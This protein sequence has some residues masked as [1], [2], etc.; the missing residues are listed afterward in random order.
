LSRLDLIVGPNGAGKTTFVALTLG[1]LLPGSV[2][3]NA[4][5]IARQR[6]PEAAAEHAYAAAEIAAATREQLIAARQAFIAET[7]FSHPSKLELLDA[8]NSAGYTTVLHVLIVPEELAVARVAA[9]VSSGGHS[10]P[11]E[12]IRQRFHRLWPLVAT[13]VRR[14]DAATIYENSR[15]Q[16]PGVVAQLA[17]GQIVGAIDWPSWT[18]GALRDASFDG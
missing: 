9:R 10:V 5:E 6:W 11:E 8:A 12:K 3:V 17:A 16:G 18:P 4:D 2:F 15:R 13:A 7:V 1:P 14:A